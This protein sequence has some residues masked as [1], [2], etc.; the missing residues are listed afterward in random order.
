MSHKCLNCKSY[1]WIKSIL[2]RWIPPFIINVLTANSSLVS[3][4]LLTVEHPLMSKCLNSKSYFWVNSTLNS[5][6]PLC[7]KCLN[8]KSYFWII[9][10]ITQSNLDSHKCLN[11]KFYFILVISKLMVS[12]LG[13][14]E[15]LAINPKLKK[16]LKLIS[17]IRLFSI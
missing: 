10:Q 9:S 8:I 11:S 16:K 12:K 3:N 5:W 4:E 14:Q 1:S 7:Y 15:A 13:S 6:V 17:L 2:N